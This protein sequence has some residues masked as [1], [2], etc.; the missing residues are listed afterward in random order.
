MK[1][2]SGY[3]QVKVSSDPARPLL[4]AIPGGR[5]KEEAHLGGGGVP[6]P[7][8]PATAAPSPSDDEIIDALLRGDDRIASQLYDRIVGTVDRTLYRIFG[9]REHDHDDLVQS[10]FE[11][12]V[13]T[14]ARQRFARACTLR[15]WASSV[16][17]HIGLNAL[18][19]RRRERRVVDRAHG[20]DFVTTTE[21]HEGSVAPPPPRSRQGTDASLEAHF[22]LER[23]RQHL[24]AMDPKKAEALFLH[25]ALGHDLAEISVLTNASVAAAQSRLVRARK[26]LMS[27]LEA[28]DRQRGP[29]AVLK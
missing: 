12:I 10:T 17:T 1:R 2:A 29:G 27:R 25:D 22:A 24:I 8:P 28:D 15:T 26:E 21:L 3:H 5:G 13:T 20:G 23:I 14:L 19:S 11:Q 7:A 18:R 6:A 16:A 9:R 4:R